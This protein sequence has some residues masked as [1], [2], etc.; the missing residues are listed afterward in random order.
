MYRPTIERSVLDWLIGIYCAFA[1]TALLSTYPIFVI[2]LQSSISE[3]NS[4]FVQI[5]FEVGNTAVT[6]VVTSFL[7]L[8]WHVPKM[9][10]ANVERKVRWWNSE[11][12][13]LVFIAALVLAS[14]CLSR[15]SWM[16]LDCLAKLNAYVDDGSPKAQFAGWSFPCQVGHEFTYTALMIWMA[17]LLCALA[18]AIY[19][20]K[21][22]LKQSRSNK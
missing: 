15:A 10:S 14:T 13:N 12:L 7:C 22:S 19:L 4:H 1:T 9:L 16:K 3:E 17:L 5:I 6:L 20:A 2:S 21:L 8:I 11:K 18:Q